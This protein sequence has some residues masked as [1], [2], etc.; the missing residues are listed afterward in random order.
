MSMERTLGGAS[1]C[2]TGEHHP[3]RHDG[4]ESGWHTAQSVPRF[5]DSRGPGSTEAALLTDS[6]MRGFAISFFT[7]R[8]VASLNALLLFLRG[9]TP[10]SCHAPKAMNG[11]FRP[12]EQNIEMLKNDGPAQRTRHNNCSALIPAERC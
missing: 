4:G 8:R 6:A 5:L 12:V 3:G 2:G 9:M 1:H 10:S 7:S 11:Q